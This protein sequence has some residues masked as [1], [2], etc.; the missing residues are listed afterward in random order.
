MGPDLHGLGQ[1][2][3]AKAYFLGFGGLGGFSRHL[4]RRD[5]LVFFGHLLGFGEVGFHACREIKGFGKGEAL[6]L[7]VISDSEVGLQGEDSSG[8]WHLQH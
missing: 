4:H 3:E 7:A 8:R 2:G 6:L 1:I 5:L